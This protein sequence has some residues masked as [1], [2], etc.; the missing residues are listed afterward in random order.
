MC[1]SDD[2]E[3]TMGESQPYSAISTEARHRTLRQE[4][5]DSVG[6]L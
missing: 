4:K 3:V 1:S 5:K 6:D 2:K